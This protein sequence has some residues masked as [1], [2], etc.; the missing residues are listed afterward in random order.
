MKFIVYLKYGFNRKYLRNR[1][2]PY[3]T[4]NRMDNK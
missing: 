3:T 4:P 2:I 1:I